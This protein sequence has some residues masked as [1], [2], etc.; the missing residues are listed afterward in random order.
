MYIGCMTG[1]VHREATYLG[2]PGKH[3]HRVYREVPTRE[4]I[5]TRIPGRLYPPGYPGRHITRVYHGVHIGYT[6]GCT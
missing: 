1:R 5:P 3:I 2:I 6:M 4:A